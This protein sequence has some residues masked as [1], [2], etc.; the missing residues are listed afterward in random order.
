M[1]TE[2]LFNKLY[3]EI[4]INDLRTF[5]STKQ[6]ET[7]VLEFK[8]GEVS[9][10]SLYKEVAAFL[11]TDG[12]L[13]IVGTPKE[14]KETIGKVSFNYCIGDLT[15]TT[16]IRSK[17][18]LMQKIY[19]NISPPPTN[20]KIKDF[21]SPE[22]NAF[23]IEVPQSTTPPHQ[24]D[25]EGKYYIRLEREAKSAPHGLVEALF[26]KRKRPAL[27][28]EINF[29]PIVT[30]E[31]ALEIGIWFKNNSNTPAKN[32]SF[33]VDVYN[34]EKVES[35]EI[36]FTPFLDRK[37]KYSGN[38]DSSRVLASVIKM[39]AFLTV[40]HKGKLIVLFAGFWCSEQDFTYRYW[41]IDPVKHEI[42][43]THTTADFGHNLM[44]TV[45]LA[46]NS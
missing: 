41:L 40:R 32:A 38:M 3:S 27:D 29:T 28:A 14:Q 15:L 4:T 37:I 36:H 2:Q 30:I 5:F 39:P 20:L 21:I 34:A 22:G 23:I 44:E 46:Y 7:S 35:S 24:V 11:N 19:T 16:T 26:N 8:S 18:W 31:N 42:I 17:D 25:D 6:E 10:E 45:D 33:I 9:L 13:I 1:L 43:S 12:G